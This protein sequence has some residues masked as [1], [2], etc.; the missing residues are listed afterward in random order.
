MGDGICCR[1]K[2]LLVEIELFKMSDQ[3]Y[4]GEL[5]LLVKRKAF[6]WWLCKMLTSLAS[7]S[8]EVQ[9]N[10]FFASIT[11]HLTLKEQNRGQREKEWEAVTHHTQ[12]Y[13]SSPDGLP[14][15]T[16]NDANWCLIDV[17]SLFGNKGN[18]RRLH[19]SN[20]IVNCTCSFPRTHSSVFINVSAV[21]SSAAVAYFGDAR[22]ASRDNIRGE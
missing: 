17:H 16:C 2:L 22:V 5:L 3:L 11:W 19:Q 1:G 20:L 7:V 12:T 9:M 15:D 14:M 8:S 21:A 13:T 10:P 18:L 6:Y 4:S